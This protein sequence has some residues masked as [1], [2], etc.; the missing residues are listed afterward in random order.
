MKDFLKR[1]TLTLRGETF[2]LREFA[3]ADWEY[4]NA[5]GKLDPLR[6]LQRG[7]MQ[8]RDVP[9]EELA[10]N[11]PAEMVTELVTAVLKLSGAMDEDA[12]KKFDAPSAASS[13][14]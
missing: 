4:I 3:F 2:Q 14:G 6:A 5:A 8:F 11:L 13:L 1:S 12:A 9:T 7:V 10:D